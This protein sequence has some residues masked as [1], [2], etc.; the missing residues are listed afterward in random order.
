MSTLLSDSRHS[1]LK[2]QSNFADAKSSRLIKRSR[3]LAAAVSVL[4]VVRSSATECF[5]ILYVWR[6]DVCDVPVS[7][8]ISATDSFLIP[9]VFE[10]SCA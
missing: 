3:F 2:F 10:A 9:Y 1:P 6:L 8:K 5:L 7:N 4:E